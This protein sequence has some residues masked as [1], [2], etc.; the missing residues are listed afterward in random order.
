MK[1]LFGCIF[2]VMAISSCVSDLSDGSVQTSE[3][4]VVSAVCTDSKSMLSSDLNVLWTEDDRIT[5]LSL[6]GSVSAVSEQGG[7]RRY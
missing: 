7:G 3:G 5:V 2:L 1:K 6:D 4:I